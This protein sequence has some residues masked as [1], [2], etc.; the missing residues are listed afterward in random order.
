MLCLT[1]NTNHM[2]RDGFVFYRGFRDSLKAL[3]EVDRVVIQAAL[4]DYGLDGIMPDLDGLHMAL[5]MAFKPQIDANNKRYENGKKGA[6]HGKRGGRPQSSTKPQENPTETPK[7]PLNNPSETPKEKVKEKEK[8][9]V[10][11]KEKEKVKGA[12]GASDSPFFNLDFSIRAKYYEAAKTWAIREKGAE[13]PEDTI[14][15]IAER[16]HTRNPDQFK[17]DEPLPIYLRRKLA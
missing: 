7:K 6:E 3:N 12:H 17:Q 13:P 5:F 1:S 8:E 9:K 14:W 11:V 2:E 4:I 16:F 15:K 10:N